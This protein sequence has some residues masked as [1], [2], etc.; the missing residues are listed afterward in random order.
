MVKEEFAGDI[1]SKVEGVKRFEC[2]LLQDVKGETA[3]HMICKLLGE[4]IKGKSPEREV[5]ATAKDIIFVDVKET[6]MRVYS[7]QKEK[8]LAFWVDKPKPKTC[9]WVKHTFTPTIEIYCK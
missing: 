7:P 4:E 6:D 1:V 8:K 2:Q 3:K 5:L 9:E